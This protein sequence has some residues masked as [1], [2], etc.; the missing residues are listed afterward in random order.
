MEPV[1]GRKFYVESE[2]EVKTPQI[3]R[4]D[5]ENEE[6]LPPIKKISQQKTLTEGGLELKCLDKVL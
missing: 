3:L 5:P 1:L 2:S 6:K 4:P